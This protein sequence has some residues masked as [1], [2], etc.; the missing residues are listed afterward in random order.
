MHKKPLLQT[1]ELRSSSGGRSGQGGRGTSLPRLPW[2]GLEPLR[3]CLDIL[4]FDDS[5]SVTGPGGTDPVGN[6]YQEAQ[7]ALNHVAR[8]TDSRRQHVSVLHFD[9][10]MGSSGVTPLAAPGALDHLRAHL[11][12][13]RGAMG[14]SDLERSLVAAAGQARGDG[15]RRARLTIFSDFELTDPDLDKVYERIGKFPGLVHAVVFNVAAPPQL[16]LDNVLIT[17]VKGID[18]PGTLARALFA[19]LTM[20]RPG[21]SRA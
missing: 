16:N 21:A 9:H 12:L 17:R 4:V 20:S 3:S 10:P 5:Y 2:P 11:Q 6:R 14:T 1:S 8:W 19:S 13:P 18:K 15:A 7:H